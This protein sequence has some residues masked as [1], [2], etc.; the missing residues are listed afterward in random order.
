MC[1]FVWSVLFVVFRKESNILMTG[2]AAT[3]TF[4]LSI[5]YLL[6]HNFILAK[7]IPRLRFEAL[8]Q[9]AKIL[10]SSTAPIVALMYMWFPCHRKMMCLFGFFFPIDYDASKEVFPYGTVILASLMTLLVVIR[11][12]DTLRRHKKSRVDQNDNC[13]ASDRTKMALRGVRRSSRLLSKLQ[14]S[15]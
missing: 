14:Q 6:F 12:R 9:L 8:R 13:R 2:Y 7:Y 15:P 10:I 4:A 11:K 5:V 3:V 1:L